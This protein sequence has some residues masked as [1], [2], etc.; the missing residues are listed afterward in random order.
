MES[1]REEDDA[2]Q[3]QTASG[4]LGG[5][6][7]VCGRVLSLTKAGLVR[8]HGPVSNRCP[9]SRAHPVASGV[10]LPSS[11]IEA[12]TS[13]LS[14]QR[15]EDCSQHPLSLSRL[16]LKPIKR[17]PRASREL[18]A[19]KLA[20]IIEAVIANHA[21]VP[22]WDRLLRFSARCLRAPIRGGRRWNLA[23]VINDQLRTEQD[24][25]ASPSPR[26][27]QSSRKQ[28]KVR[29]P[30]ESLA[31]LVASK[32]EEGN[33][34]GAV[35]IA[36]SEVSVAPMNNTT[37][38]ALKKKH[39][40]PHPDPQ[41]PPPPEEPSCCPT[42]SVEAVAS[43]IR[44]FPNGSAGGPDG[45]RPQHL[46]DLTG[47]SAQ[48]GGPVLLSALTSLVNLI[49]QGKIPRTVRPFFFGANLTA[50]TK[51][52]GGVRPIA[53][54]CTLRRLAAKT[55]GRYIMDAMGELLA[56]RQLGYGT[57]LGCEAA[58]HATRLYLRNLQSG[59]VLLKLDFENAF[60]CIRRDKMLQAVSDLAPELAPFVHASYSEPSTLFW[61]ETSLMSAEGVQQG[62]PLGPL[63]FCL[64]I[65]K[66]TSQL[67]SEFC[68]FYLDDGTLGGDA[69][70]TL[71]D[72]RSVEL[73][74]KELGLCLNHVKC[75]VISEDPAATGVLL[76]SAPNLQVTDPEFATLLGSPL[77]SIDSVN[78]SICGKVESLRIL[79]DRLEHLHIQDSL[80]LL[81]HSLAI[82][83]LSYT[84]RTCPCF[85]SPEIKAYDDLLKSITSRITNTSLHISDTT[86]IQASLPVK[87][88]GLGIRSAAQLAPS[89]FLASAAGSSTLVA[90]IV[91]SRLQEFPIVAREEALSYWSHG[92]NNPPPPNSVSHR[93]REWDTPRVKVSAQ[94]LLEDA[95]DERSRARLLAASRQETG[96][97]LNALPVSSLGLRM[98]NET[99][100]V[101]VGLRLGT[102]L[103]RPHECCKCGTM[104]DDLATH[105]LS[106]RF[107][108]GRHPRHAAI[109]DII[110]RALTSAKIPSRL[111]PSGLYR[112][113]GKRPD[114]CSILPWRSGKVLVWDAT[115]PDTY[116]PSHVS[117]AA[118]DPGAVAAQAEHLKMTKY[119][120]LE[121]DYFFVPFAIETSGV[122]GQAA[123]EF[124]NDLGWC[125]HHATGEP[126]SKEYLLQRL[127]VA[128]QR[129]NAAAVL[130]T[131]GKNGELDPFWE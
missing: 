33:V 107:S 44:S 9:G 63:L 102:T 2:E 45:L 84:L 74:A 124:V 49:L 104:V 99:A 94:A 126:R 121:S 51:K 7:A 110:Q 20:S 129:G 18:A 50:L 23:R 105:G 17:I 86:W 11:N 69:E 88:G 75:E 40:P 64:T 83:R 58:V 87:N 35:R 123:W 71:Q 61:G 90:Q 115:C 5:P 22:A 47:A 101:A 100:R 6:C 68:L 8:T 128:I 98:D 89:A 59:Q 56:P 72:L 37:L 112:S 65:H 3:L 92:H 109:N 117:T 77:G 43:A 46:K 4:G 125:L 70:Q 111:E 13:C 67:K 97:W 19:K 57:A 76:A 66:L 113:D 21:S 10:S 130:G 106:C 131:A 16:R 120:H 36:C 96:A 118:R 79:G 26:T 53:V 95:P 38:D 24:P 80:L 32:L 52:D 34:T 93:Q 25:P 78:E 14:A 82:P 42:I 108:E 73:G 28:Q 127:S 122:L 54:G 55:A 91:P 81:R 12:P 48:S 114:G 29:D 1:S 62:D 119:S 60:N 27:T 39:P 103:C 116:A 85:L 41:M 15:E 30:L 31:A